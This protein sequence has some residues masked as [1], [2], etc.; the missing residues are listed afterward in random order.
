MEPFG[1]RIFHYRRH[2]RFDFVFYFSGIGG[3]AVFGP[4]G[5]L[6]REASWDCGGG[7]S[8]S[9]MLL[10]G[11]LG[12]VWLWL[13]TRTPV[14]RRPFIYADAVLQRKSSD[15]SVCPH[16]GQFRHFVTEMGYSGN[17]LW[18]PIT[19]FARNSPQAIPKAALPGGRQGCQDGAQR[20]TRSPGEQ[21]LTAVA[22]GYRIAARELEGVPVNGGQS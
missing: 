20:G 13:A 19:R 7:S 1:L 17:A 5:K 18:A 11:S 21:Y 8:Y 14:L 15:V 10:P 2:L 3:N 4:I 12:S 6:A 16:G 9:H 22:R